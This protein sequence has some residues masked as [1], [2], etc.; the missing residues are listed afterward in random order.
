[1]R[2]DI[3]GLLIGDPHLMSE[4]PLASMLVIEETLRLVKEKSPDFVVVMGDTL[5][6]HSRADITPI[7][8]ATNWFQEL[9]K[10]APTYVLIG[11]HDLKDPG[12]FLTEEHC[13]YANKFIE[14]GPQIIDKVVK[15]DIKGYNL[16][17]MPYVPP[18]RMM[19]AL[20]TIGITEENI[21]DQQIDAIFCHQDV[22]AVIKGIDWDGDKWLACNPM[23]YSGHIHHYMKVL[24]N[25]LY[26]GSSRQ[27]S[28]AE[29]PPKTVSFVTFKH[30]DQCEIRLKLNVPIKQK[31]EINASEFKAGKYPLP[32]FNKMV[33]YYIYV[34]GEIAMVEALKKSKAHKTWKL[35]RKDIMVNYPP[36]KSKDAP[37]NELI[38]RIDGVKSYRDVLLEK[39]KGTEMEQDLK[40]ILQSLRT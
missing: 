18:G 34:I 9:Q 20:G 15:V 23:V 31:I 21:T 3:T 39:V 2:D 30:E 4:A 36:L 29:D 28:C 7:K 38:S 8:W 14:S 26:V 12:Q 35:S 25:W 37:G 17:M 22:E 27:V 10:I 6:F 1:M 32:A 13:F 24:N 19:E 40:D 5:H 33:S 16:I 11:N